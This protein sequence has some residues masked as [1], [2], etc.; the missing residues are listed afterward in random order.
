[1]TSFPATYEATRDAYTISTDPALLDTRAVHAYVTHAYRATGRTYEAVARALQHSLCFGLYCDDKQIGLARVV[2]DYTVFAYL[3]DVYILD[4][5]QGQ[6]LGKWL[7]ESALH[8]PELK[9]VRR[10]TLATRDAHEFYAAY[11]FTAL[12]DP[13]KYMELFC[14]PAT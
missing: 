10:W 2:T 9:S 4:E 8:H 3:C 5:Y 14:A 11:G 12:V 1:M 13:A 7:I 6:G